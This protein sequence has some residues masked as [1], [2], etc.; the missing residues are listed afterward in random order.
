MDVDTILDLEQL[1]VDGA[2]GHIKAAVIILHPH[3]SDPMKIVEDGETAIAYLAINPEFDFEEN[4]CCFY[5]GEDYAD[6]N[7]PAK[8]I[9]CKECDQALCDSYIEEVGCLCSR[10]DNQ[11]VVI[12]R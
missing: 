12:D 6:E 8:I 5:C 7:P 1:E 11:E 4:V 3:C 10:K 2:L 9:P